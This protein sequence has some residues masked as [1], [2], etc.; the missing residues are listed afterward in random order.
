MI[1]FYPGPSKVWDQL[2][3]YM[4]AAWQEGVLS[5]NHRSPEFVTI[6]RETIRLLHDHLQIPE[7]YTIFFTSS[8]TECWEIIAQSV[9]GKAKSLH[10]YNGAFGEKWQEYTHKLSGNAQAQPFSPEELP[11]ANKLQLEGNPLLLALTHNETSNGTALPQAFIREVRKRYP[12]LL[13]AI[14]A[15]SS[16]AGVELDYKLADVWYAS[17][18]KCFGL[19]AGLALMI[20]SPGA[21]ARVKVL[22]EQLHYNSLLFMQEKIADAQTTYTPNVLGIYLLMRSLQDRPTITQTASLLQERFQQWI[23]FF[24]DYPLFQLLIRN[25]AVRS[26]TVLT[27]QGNAEEVAQLKKKAQSAGLYVGNGYGRWKE[28]SF[29]IA[30]FPAITEEEISRLKSFLIEY[31]QH[32]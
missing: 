30:N 23:K 32:S 13:I 24:S 8:A 25:A 26:Q 28:S 7:E 2:P 12:D 20:C 10:L 31:A 1:S 11:V 9:I 19:P 22:N 14:D 17:V 27:L 6:S 29:R 21:L 3:Q 4:Q 15:T 5:I 16:M 18:Q